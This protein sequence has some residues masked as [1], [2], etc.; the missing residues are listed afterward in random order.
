VDF[1]EEGGE[2]LSSL[3]LR[4]LRSGLWSLRSGL[5]AGA[6]WLRLRRLKVALLLFMVAALL[7]SRWRGLVEVLLLISAFLIH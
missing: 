7:F 6:V 5:V 3:W 2:L 1:L 4:S